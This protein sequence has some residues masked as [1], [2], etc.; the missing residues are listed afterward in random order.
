MQDLRAELEQSIDEA[1]WNW[2]EP[3]AR[4]D[5]LIVVAPD[6]DLVDVGIAIASDNTL[7]VRRLI[8]EALI[9][10]PSPAQLSDWMQHQDKRF[11]A[12]IVQPYV[13]IQ[14]FA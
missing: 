6:L 9:Q 1:E 14:E 2:L 11:S 10:K 12:L 8:E 5:S 4:R 13:L 3:H 7:H